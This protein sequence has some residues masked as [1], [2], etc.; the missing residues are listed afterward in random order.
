[1]RT[2]TKAAGIIAAALL[3][4]AW[5]SNGYL[6]ATAF[7]V[8]ASGM[9]GYARTVA[10]VETGRF[11]ER[12]LTIPW[13]GG[14]MRAR[15]Y[16]PH[17]SSDRAMLLVPGVHAAGVDEPRLVQFAR[18]LAS[19]NHTVLTAE[20]IDL[21]QYRITPRT[22]DMIEDAALWLSNQRDLA[23]DGQVG[24]M[25]IS[26][27]GGLSIIAASRESLRDR[28]A[29]VMSFGGHGDLPRTLR[30]LCTG[31]QPDGTHRPPHDYGV[32]IILLSVVDQ[33]VPPDQVEPLR[34]VIGTYL[35][36]SRLDL[37]D[38]NESWNTY[39]R[40][41]AMTASLPEPAKTL[42]GY[43]NDRDVGHLGPI[44]LPHVTEI[45]D[46][47]MLSPAREAAPRAP[48]YLLH[49][50]DDNVIPAIE[51]YLLADTLRQRGVSVHQ[52]AT[53]LITHAEVD[54]TST[55]SA[56]WRLVGFW[57]DLLGE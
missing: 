34:K 8:Q 23:R 50:T 21:T 30:Y 57:A 52:L 32:V 39:Q 12:A 28:V 36:A 48:V 54:R 24:M 3:L 38:K 13:R 7:V 9:Q 49:G 33:V 2:R 17:G 40:A 14:Q 10:S 29:F 55:A 25:G 1:M 44:L 42:M 46:D 53:P 27:A 43:V 51:S 22:T 16:I 41:R 47:R 26:F 6:R 11:D 56:M 37:V 4:G 35:D 31:I 15:L 18:D 19:V 5:A 20:L 45:G